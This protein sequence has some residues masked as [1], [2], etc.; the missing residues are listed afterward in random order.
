[1]EKE[2]QTSRGRG[3]RA[4]LMALDGGFL[5]GF[6]GSGVCMNRGQEIDSLVSRLWRT[7]PIRSANDD[8]WV[9]AGVRVISVLLL[10]IGWA[11]GCSACFFLLGME[12][13]AGICGVFSGVCSGLWCI[14]LIRL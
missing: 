12:S 7:L 9:S 11:P 2:W 14:L 5:S 3:V 8:W 1:M 4:I 10:S 13:D 6:G